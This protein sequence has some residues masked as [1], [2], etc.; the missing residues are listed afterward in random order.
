MGFEMLLG[1]ERLRENISRSIRRGHISHFYLISGPEG[2]GKHTLARLMAAAILCTGN[3]K[4]CQNCAAC[5]KVLSDAHPDFITVD[6]PEKKTIS[7]DLVRDAR[8]DIYIRPNEADKKI[9][10]FPRAQDMGIPAQNALLKILEEPPAYGVFLLLAD[11]PEKLLPTI[12]S[13]CTELKLTVLPETL[14]RSNLQARFPDASMEDIQ[15]AMVRSGGY[16]GQASRLLEEGDVQCPHTESLIRCL[17]ARDAIGL[18]SLLV[19]MERWKRDQFLPVL[20]RWEE[21]LQSALVCRSGIHALSADVRQLSI[22]R[23]SSELLSAIRHIQ[24]AIEYAQ[25]NVS[26]AAICGYLLWALQ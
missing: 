25:G 1:N 13:R 18:A 16:L 21:A 22:S 24:K 20:S 7:V 12:R 5:R 3:E 19:P 17:T 15:A 8:A 4:P 23:S 2:S 26:V 9:Y 14:L 10:L 11:N 6:D